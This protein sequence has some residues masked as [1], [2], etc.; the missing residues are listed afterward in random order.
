MLLK[1]KNKKDK[2]NKLDS[3]LDLYFCYIFLPITSLYFFI[4]DFVFFFINLRL[5]LIIKFI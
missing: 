5:L 1:I 3:C 2:D 4:I